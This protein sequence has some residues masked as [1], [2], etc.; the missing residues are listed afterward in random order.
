MGLGT[1]LMKFLSGPLQEI[2]AFAPGDVFPHLFVTGN[3]P[4]I[5]QYALVSSIIVTFVAGVLG[6]FLIIRNLALI[7]GWFG[8]CI[9]WRDM[10]WLG[11][12]ICRSNGLCACILRNRGYFDF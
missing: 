2:G 11:S 10:C 9:L 8:S 5:F 7:G 4:G 6:S 12:G 1:I 3:G